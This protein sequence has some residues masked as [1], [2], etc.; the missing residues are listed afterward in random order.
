MKKWLHPL[1]RV[2]DKHLLAVRV[3]EALREMAV[4]WV[5]FA[6][7]D[8]L[9]AEKLTLQWV[10]THCALALVGWVVALYIEFMSDRRRE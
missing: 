9:V 3:S 4:L 2:I 1:F 8:K 7:L 10:A 6:V 5:V